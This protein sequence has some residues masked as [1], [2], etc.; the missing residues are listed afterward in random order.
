M[1][2]EDDAMA[3]VLKLARAYW[4]TNEQAWRAIRPY[5]R[6]IVTAVGVAS[7]AMWALGVA[8]G[9]NAFQ[10]APAIYAGT[11]LSSYS[12]ARYL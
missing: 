9:N 12:L 2:G 10:W 11:L 4:R 1:T 6:P 3:F 8:H 5:A 7:V